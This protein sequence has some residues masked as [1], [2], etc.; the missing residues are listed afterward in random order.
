MWDGVGSTL[1]L[2]GGEE[3]PEVV[4]LALAKT[5]RSLGGRIVLTMRVEGEKPFRPD[6][7]SLESGV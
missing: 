4:H 1:S 2:F 3:T 7:E 6:L 5:V